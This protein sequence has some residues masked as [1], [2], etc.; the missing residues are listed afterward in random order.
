MLP[1]KFNEEQ[2]FNEEVTKLRQRFDRKASNSL[3]LPNSHSK[4][5]PMDRLPAFIK[6]I[7]ATI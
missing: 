7:W 6:K 4:D 2:K 5:I 1:D 3:F